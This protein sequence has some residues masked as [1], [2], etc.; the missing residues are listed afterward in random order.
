MSR[1][2]LQSPA[3]GSRDLTLRRDG[4]Q[5]RAGRVQLRAVEMQ[6][7]QVMVVPM[8]LAQTALLDVIRQYAE[9]AEAVLAHTVGIADQSQAALAGAGRQAATGTP[10]GGRQQCGTG[11]GQP[12]EAFGVMRFEGDA[13]QAIGARRI[14]GLGDGVVTQRL[15]TPARAGVQQGGVIAQ[16]LLMA[17]ACQ[18][19]AV[20]VGQHQTRLP[21]IEQVEGMTGH[22]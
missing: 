21:V 20:A 1:Q 17:V 16:Q 5:G 14:Q 9:H 19:H 2:Q 13:C 8:R 18:H 3:T 11:A 7:Q 22:R 15:L 4:Q 6:A 12:L 10:A